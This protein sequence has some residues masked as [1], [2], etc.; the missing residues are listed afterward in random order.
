MYVCMYKTIHLS[1]V[2]HK[3]ICKKREK[4]NEPA[5]ETA[6]EASSVETFSFSLL[7]SPNGKVANAGAGGKGA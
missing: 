3:C 5:T 7:L 2:S 6:D 4:K 1:F